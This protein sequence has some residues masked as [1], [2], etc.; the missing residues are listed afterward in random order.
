MNRVILWDLDGTLLYTLQ[1]ILNATNA[2]L[3]HFGYPAITLEALRRFVGNGA[4]NQ[5]RL[6]CGGT[7]P[8][9]FADMMA[10]YR[11]YYPMH[12]NETTKPYDGILELAETLQARGWHLGIVSNK[13][14]NATKS[15]WQVYFPS[16]DLALG[17]QKGLS[18]KPAPDMVLRAMELLQADPART[19]FVG[20]SEVDLATARAAGLPCIS[21]AWGYR[22][23]DV[24]LANG[25]EHLCRSPRDFL[26]VLK[27]AGYGE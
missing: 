2:T 26:Q 8:E 17:E 21:A 10:W 25:A 16:F 6:S 23:E 27:E 20:D 11:A 3:A 14:D 7:E 13:P 18:R 12:C 15:L 9:N 1:D 19:V 22:D 24:L 4:A 5:M